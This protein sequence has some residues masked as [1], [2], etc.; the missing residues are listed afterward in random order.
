MPQPPR[1]IYI[2]HAKNNS[3]SKGHHQIS[4][5]DRPANRQSNFIIMFSTQN[6]KYHI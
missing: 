4:T 1:R 2:D 3:P 5:A 6:V